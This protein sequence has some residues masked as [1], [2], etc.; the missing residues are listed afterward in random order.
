MPATELPRLPVPDSPFRIPFDASFAADDVRSS[1]DYPSDDYK[2]R[3]RRLQEEM[4]AL[5]RALYAGRSHSVLLIFQALDAAGKDSTIRSVFSGLDPAGVQVSAFKAPTEMEL[6]HDFL[7][8]TSLCLPARGLIGIFNR[9]YYEEV[10]T[11][12]VHP[13]FLN[14]QYPGG[15]PDPDALWAARYAAIRAHEKHLADSGTL[16]LKFWLNVSLE[17]QYR[18]F[19]SRIDEPH[20]QWKFNSRDVVESHYRDA[21]ADA[22]VSMVNETSRP[23]APWYLIPADN[24]RSMRLIV[25]ETVLAGLRGLNPQ[26]PVVDAEAQAEF[27]TYRDQLKSSLPSTE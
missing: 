26:Y 21:Y 12:K 4:D 19:L 3:L 2:K 23:Y 18:R 15:V 24:K 22:F 13:E 27:D 1:T 7:W 11:V 20:K 6:R 25:A 14:A 5:Q 9:S 16:V 17:E 10:L 8:R